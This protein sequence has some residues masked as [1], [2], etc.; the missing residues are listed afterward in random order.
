MDPQVFFGCQKKWTLLCLLCNFVK[1][2]WYSGLF[3]TM[4]PRFDLWPKKEKRTAW[5]I[6]WPYQELLLVSFA[7]ETCV[8]FWSLYFGPHFDCKW[9]SWRPMYVKQQSKWYQIYVFTINSNTYTFKKIESRRFQFA[10]LNKKNH[11]ILLQKMNQNPTTTLE[12]KIFTL[13]L[14]ALE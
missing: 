9:G 5:K 14:K 3:G 6:L 7:S 8:A 4:D 11:K 1:R 10:T 2:S 13:T 12:M